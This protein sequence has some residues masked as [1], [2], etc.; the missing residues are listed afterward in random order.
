V[1]DQ[2]AEAL[3]LIAHDLRATGHLPF[4]FI[5][6]G[7]NVGWHG[8]V[9]PSLVESDDADWRL[10]AMFEV[11]GSRRG[12]FVWRDLDLS[13]RLGMLLE[14]I[15]QE[16]L[17]AR[18]DAGLWA[19]WPRCPAHPRTHPLVVS[20]DDRPRWVCPLDGGP[21]LGEVGTLTNDPPQ[22]PP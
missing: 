17:E 9:D 3:D 21:E 22:D 15:Q 13:S 7:W 12:I 4:R 18:A 14:D 19:Y 6:E 1:D 2:M 8:P 10:E 16:M 11:A 5:D 20:A